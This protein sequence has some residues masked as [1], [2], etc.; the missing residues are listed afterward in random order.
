MKKTKI[1]KIITRLKQSNT[2]QYKQMKKEGKLA[3]DIDMTKKLV[4]RYLDSVL[5]LLK[6]KKK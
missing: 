5:R 1:E 2:V 3:W 6:E 4:D